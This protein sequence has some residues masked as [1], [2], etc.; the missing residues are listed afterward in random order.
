MK[1]ERELTPFSLIRSLTVLH[2]PEPARISPNALQ[3]SV[4]EMLLEEGVSPDE[5]ASAFG[6][7]YVKPGSMYVE[8]KLMLCLIAERRISN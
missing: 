4:S 1:V 6:F 5:M 3:Y 2:K 8:M 7:E